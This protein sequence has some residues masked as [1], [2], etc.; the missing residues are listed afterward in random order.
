MTRDKVYKIRDIIQK[1]SSFLDDKDASE[2]PGLTRTM[3][4][5]GLL[6]KVNTRINWKGALMR[7]RNDLWDTEENNPDNAPDLWEQVLYR[8]G[9]RVI[10]ENIPA[11]DPFYKGDLG[12]WGDDLYESIADGANVYNPEQYPSN[13]SKRE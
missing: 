12:W 10:P 2:Y 7:A 13:W 9:I 4:Y 8:N 11:T 3:K 5:D 6:I 1:A